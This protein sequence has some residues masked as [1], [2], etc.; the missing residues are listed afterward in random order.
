MLD[1]AEVQ[2]LL[3]FHKALDFQSMQ[4]RKTV[5]TQRHKKIRLRHMNS[6]MNR[7][8]FLN[9]NSNFKSGGSAAEK[10]LCVKWCGACSKGEKPKSW[11]TAAEIEIIGKMDCKCPGEYYRAT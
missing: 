7:A 4:W 8:N 3:F 9:Y 5:G 6:N 10:K 11:L 1:L 2:L